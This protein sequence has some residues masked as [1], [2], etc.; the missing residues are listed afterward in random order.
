GP[1]RLAGRVRRRTRGRH[2]QPR[3]ARPVG[4]TLALGRL[5]RLGVTGWRVALARY[6]SRAASAAGPEAATSS[7]VRRGRWG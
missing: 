6:A 1:V 7:R 2:V 3:E 5:R 4:L